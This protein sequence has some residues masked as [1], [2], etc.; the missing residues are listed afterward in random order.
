MIV[1]VLLRLILWLSF[2]QL[3]SVDLNVLSSGTKIVHD[4]AADV[5]KA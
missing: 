3:C 2:R 5:F 4:G 1:Q